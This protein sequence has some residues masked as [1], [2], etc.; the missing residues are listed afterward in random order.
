MILSS[1]A[2][3]MS[4]RN[5]PPTIRAVFRAVAPLNSLCRADSADYR[6]V[7]FG[8]NSGCFN[9][10]TSELSSSS[11]L[12]PL[13]LVCLHLPSEA[14]NFNFFSAYCMY[15]GDLFSKFD[16]A[17]AQGIHV[18]LCFQCDCFQFIYLY[19]SNLLLGI[20]LWSFGCLPSN[21]SG[22]TQLLDVLGWPCTLSIFRVRRGFSV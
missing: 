13:A 2:H 11:E 17:R 6:C 4:I 10:C 20:Y 18:L 19:K 5:S 1:L 16:S 22:F 8:C 7:F 21:A 3:L 14:L 9:S 12:L 15:Y